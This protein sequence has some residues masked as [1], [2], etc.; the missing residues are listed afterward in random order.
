MEKHMSISDIKVSDTF[1]N[2]IP[3]ES[4]MRECRDFWNKNHKQDRYI[5]VN[6]NNVLID[7][8]VQYLVL[9]ENGVENAMVK[10]RWSRHNSLK[11]IDYEHRTLTYESKQKKCST[12][13]NEPTT[14]IYGIHEKSNSPK[15]YMWRVPKKWDGWSDELEIG[16]SVW[17][18]TKYGNCKVKVVDIKTLNECPV[19]FRVKRVASKR[20]I[21][22]S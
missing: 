7:G 6:Y 5:V 14:Y 2:S 16:N 3:K 20:I 10:Q 1:A 18:N 12:Y 17:V 19:D 4:K 13:R 22:E 15:V 11:R 9:K 8:Y 21:K